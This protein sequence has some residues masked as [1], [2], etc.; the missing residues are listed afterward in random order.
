MT[1][2]CDGHRCHSSEETVRFATE[3]NIKLV[4]S[5]AYSSCMNPVE[6]CWLV[7]KTG[8]RAA[9]AD[10]DK[11]TSHSFRTMVEAGLDELRGR[12]LRRLLFSTAKLWVQALEG[13]ELA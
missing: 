8:L 5:P 11:L 13:R 12:D 6:R 4:Y 7:L 2:V 10:F 3:N 1:V 9:L